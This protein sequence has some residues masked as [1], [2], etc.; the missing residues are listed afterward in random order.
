[1]VRARMSAR[2]LPVL[3]LALLA[4]LV[5]AI[6]LHR[7]GAPLGQP[8]LSLVVAAPGLPAPLP[9]E[10]RATYRATR[11]LPFL[12]CRAD[13]SGGPEKPIEIERRRALELVPGPA[14][15]LAAVPRT[16]LSLA[17]FELAAIS[18]HLGPGAGEGRVDLLLGGDGSC[19]RRAPRS[20][21]ELH[22]GAACGRIELTLT[23]PPPPP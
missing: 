10:L 3:L 16:L 21:G 6:A 23:P 14:R 19:R 13:W 20:G 1:M 8:A 18:L 22:I 2:F 15:E 11:C 12:T 9:L 7:S 4:P 17:G 5:A